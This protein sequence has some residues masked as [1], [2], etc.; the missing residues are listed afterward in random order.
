MKVTAEEQPK[1][2]TKKDM[3]LELNDNST[4][5]LSGIK[6]KII[7]KNLT[8]ETIG[9]ETS[10]AIIRIF[11]TKYLSLKLFWLICLLG[12]VSLCGYLV[13][14]TFIV[15]LS[16]PV[17]TTT[18]LVNE[19]PTVFPKITICNSNIPTT[20]YAFEMIKGINEE[21]YPNLSIFN[22]TQMSQLAWKD[23]SEIFWL[24]FTE[25]QVRVNSGSFSDVERRK[26]VHSFEDTLTHCTFNGQTCTSNDFIWKWNPI[27]GNCYV[28]NSGFNSNGSKVS[29]KES[30]LP[31]TLSGLQLVAY[32]GYNDK[33]IP[34]NLGLSWIPFSKIF[35]LN[36]L[37]ENN[38]YLGFDK[39][40]VIAL[41]GG[42]MNF[43]PIHRRF[44][45]KLPKPYSN[46]DIDNSNPSKFDSPFYNLIKN[47]PYQYSQELCI[48]Q[49][50]QQQIINLCNCST[51]LYVSLYNSSCKN[52]NESL[53]A[54][55]G[56]LT[57]TISSQIPNC[58][59]Q[60][61][62]ECNSTEISF[63]LTSQ[64][65]SGNG[66][67]YL[68]NESHVL[69]SDFIATPITDVTASN[70]FVQLSAYYDSLSF[71]SSEDSP[72]MDIVA[73]LGN[74]GGTLGLFLGI[75]VLSV[76]ECIHVIV[77]SCILVK[78]RLKDAKKIKN[79]LPPEDSRI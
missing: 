49:C 5:L 1:E 56:P 70:K 65:I 55:W 68:V 24:V 43:M 37:I 45:L 15:Y 9:N 72:S 6:T 27:Y 8:K 40:N 19:V 76:C 42:T 11:D 38:T 3:L 28:F 52:E 22:Q 59:P 13:A 73:F 14:Q 77:E 47:S 66:Y 10:Q 16:Y 2:L 31:G 60:C 48:L 39:T 57:G 20:E 61:P 23:A 78:D 36:V 71:T 35:G 69:S 7:I 51:P 63:T 30:V 54:Y 50:Y 79:D 41:N 67:A 62:L 32:V 12:C 17:Y 53:C 4:P 26:L 34:F 33:L 58:I 74:I 75:S 29:F 21:F 25:F 44:A 64:T 18:T 46:C